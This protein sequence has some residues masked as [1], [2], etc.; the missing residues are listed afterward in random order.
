MYDFKY[1]SIYYDTNNKMIGV[2]CG[3]KPNDNNYGIRELDIYFEFELTTNDDELETFLIKVFYA[4][5]SKVSANNEP[6]AL[7]KYTGKKGY[8]AAAKGF[9]HMSIDW[10]EGKG[11]TFHPMQVD[12]KH[13][14]AFTSIKGKLSINVTKH[15]KHIPLEKGALALAFRKAKEIIDEINLL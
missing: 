5:Y 14:G 2:P 11:Y 4:C 8:A 6:T 15:N 12:K 7:Q 1:I 13:K 10:S 3:K 9:Q